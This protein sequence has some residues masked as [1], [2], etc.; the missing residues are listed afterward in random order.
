MPSV[1]LEPTKIDL[2]G[3]ADHP[4]QSHWGRRRLQPNKERLAHYYEYQAVLTC[5]SCQNGASA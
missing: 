5:P 2:S 4:Y 1:R 3:H